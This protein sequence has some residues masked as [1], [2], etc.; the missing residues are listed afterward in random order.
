VSRVSQLRL[1]GNS[2]AGQNQRAFGAVSPTAG[3]TYLK[4]FLDCR[5]LSLVGPNAVSTLAETTANGHLKK[6]ATRISSFLGARVTEGR[7]CA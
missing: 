5:S 6:W 3:V 2:G 7:K 1:A 4:K